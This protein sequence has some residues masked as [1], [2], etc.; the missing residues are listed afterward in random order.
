MYNYESKKASQVKQAS[1]QNQSKSSKA[2]Q[3]QAKETQANQR[4]KY[5]GETRV[6]TL[7]QGPLRS[8]QLGMNC[9]IGMSKN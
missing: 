1:K 2:N 4:N 5:T 9:S 3:S 6:A 7:P 8:C